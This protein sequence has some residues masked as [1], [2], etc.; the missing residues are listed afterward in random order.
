VDD[1]R[2]MQAMNASDDGPL[3]YPEGRVS[4]AVEGAAAD[5]VVADLTAA[6]FPADTIGGM[7]GA[8]DARRFRD[9]HDAGGTWGLVKRIALS[10]GS[11]LD[12]A[13]RAEQELLAGNALVEVVVDGDD[14]KDR[15]REIL[16]RHGGH[17][18]NYFDRW[19][20]ET[21]G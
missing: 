13:R 11:D 20:I 2:R 19:T 3:S 9:L 17:F 5:A 4:G 14:A 12:L 16:L 21:L 15:V 6:G 18:V 7:A 10:M 8:E 1:Q